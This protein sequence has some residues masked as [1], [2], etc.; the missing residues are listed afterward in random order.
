[1]SSATNGLLGVFK[2]LSGAKAR[3]DANYIRPGRYWA[4][5]N[6]VVLKK[7]RKD[8]TFI[9]I[10]MTVL[11]IHD[12]A[13]LQQKPG[14]HCHSVREAMTHMMMAK[15]DSFLGNVKAFLANVLGVNEAEI[16]EDNAVEV[17]SD[18]QPLSGTIVEVNAH[19]IVTRKNTDFTAVNYMREVRAEE[20]LAALPA[21][22][23]ARYFPGNYLQN[24]AAAEAAQAKG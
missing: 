15:H 2:G 18:S 9:A 11:A 10:E 14:Q 13:K 7:S 16:T 1:M 19:N 8:D 21:E 17:C 20:A 4:R 6:K 23:V 12:D 22:I 5:I 3:V 24:V